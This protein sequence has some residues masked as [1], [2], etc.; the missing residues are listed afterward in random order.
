MKKDTFANRL[1]KAME[2]NNFKQ[3][4]L[5]NKTKIDKTLINK[6]LN[7]VSEA[8]SDKLSILGRALN[9]NE[10]WLMGY[11][12]PISNDS[13]KKTNLSLSLYE[14][15][16]YYQ[17]NT[18]TLSNLIEIDKKRLDSFINQDCLPTKKELNLIV[19]YFNLKEENDLFNGNVIQKIISI[20]KITLFTHRCCLYLN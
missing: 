19:N 10:V 11:D 18:E 9:V 2:L 7:G 5:V 15:L 8:G 17:L 1:N 16:R 12:V 3:I 13:E 14:L 4:D 20:K 6:Y